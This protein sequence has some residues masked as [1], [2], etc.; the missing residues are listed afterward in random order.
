M[1]PRD[2]LPCPFHKS[3]CKT[4]S[5]PGLYCHLFSK[6][7]AEE[8]RNQLKKRAVVYLKES[9]KSLPYLET[10][11][12]MISF[13]M[14]CRKMYMTQKTDHWNSCKYHKEHLERFARFMGPTEHSEE[15]QNAEQAEEILALKKKITALEKDLKKAVADLETQQEINEE[16]SQNCQKYWKML[17][18]ILG[19]MP[20]ITTDDFIVIAEEIEAGKRKT[21]TQ[22]EETPPSA[23]AP[24]AAPPTQTKPQPEILAGATPNGIPII[25]SVKKIFKVPKKV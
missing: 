3:G 12:K 21:Y 10:E 25:T 16:D 17:K 2:A 8:L 22:L 13:C 15:A 6:T 24:V 14:G 18:T 9:T 19:L 7:H 1:E 11:D 5:R 4:L 20:P 23:P